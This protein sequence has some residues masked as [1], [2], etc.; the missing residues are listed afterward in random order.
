MIASP[1]KAEV[2]F[3]LGPVPV[4]APVATTW[5]LMA[6]L[7]PARRCDPPAEAGARDRTGGPGAAGPRRSRARSA[8]PCE[9]TRAPTC[10]SWPALFIFIAGCNLL[11]L[12]PGL[13][14]PTAHLETDAALAVI[15]FFAVHVFGVRARGLSGYLADFAK[16]SL[17]HAA[18]Q[19]DLGVHPH[20]LADGAPVRQHHERRVRDR[21][22]ALAGRPARADPV[23]GARAAHRPDPG[24]HLHR[25]GHGLHR[26]GGG[27]APPAQGKARHELPRP[28]QHPGRRLRR[29]HGR[30]SAPRSPRGAPSPPP[31]TPSPA[32]RTPPA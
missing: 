14:P 22:R 9:P 13:E 17:D 5:G 19:P 6:V 31:W 4:T 30:A 2:L 15:V 18:A 3:H 10:R 23:H 21:H 25:P 32:S 16:P 8:R 28:R 11:A 27:P 7:G 1:L 29:R 24:L 26:R 20:L 12:V